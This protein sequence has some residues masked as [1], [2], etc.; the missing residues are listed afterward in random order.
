MRI[1]EGRNM[2]SILLCRIIAWQMGHLNARSKMSLYSSG[3]TDNGPNTPQQSFGAKKTWS[4]RKKPRN[5]VVD[6]VFVECLECGIW[7]LG[8]GRPIIIINLLNFIFRFSFS[9]YCAQRK[10]FY[11]FFLSLLICSG[12]WMRRPETNKR[13]RNCVVFM[14]NVHVRRRRL[15]LKC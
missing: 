12:F 9:F 6:V 1:E 13:W 7:M 2:F 8:H 4:K 15:Q 14:Y 3:C 5:S 10:M 11:R